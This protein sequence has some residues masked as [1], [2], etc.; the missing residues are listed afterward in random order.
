[1]K[2]KYLEATAKVLSKNKDGTYTVGFRCSDCEGGYITTSYT[3]ADKI[4][5][6][7]GDLV[8]VTISAITKD[9]IINIELSNGVTDASYMPD[10]IQQ[11]KDAG[12]YKEPEVTPKKDTGQ[13][14]ITEQLGEK[15]YKLQDTKTQKYFVGL[16]KEELDV[17][18]YADQSD[19]ERI[20]EEH[21]M[22]DYTLIHHWWDN[23]KF[24]HWDLFMSDGCTMTHMVLE[25]DPLKNFEIK[26]AQRQPYTDDFWLRGEKMESI[27]PGEPGNP[28]RDSECSIERIDKGKVAVY[29]SEQQA[30]ESYLLRLEFFGSALE[31]RWAFTSSV[32][33]VWHALKETTKL[34]EQFQTNIALSGDIAAWKETNDGLEVTGTALSFGTWNGLYWSP[35]VILNSPLDDFDNMIVDVE[36]DNDKIAGS[37]LEKKIDGPDVKEKFK[38]TDYEII[39]KIK[40]GTYT[41]LSIDARTFVDPIRRVV[42]GVKKYTR[43]TVCE[44]PACK[45]CYFGS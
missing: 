7:E 2:K 22:S 41:G 19:F 1:M 3:P 34:S 29:E 36:H 33:N 12:I 9:Q 20:A 42:A 24:E 30:D 39:E 25:G 26:A 11:A 10:L 28:S 44:N 4:E 13:Y 15:V 43:L 21:E 32:P 37:V 27:A 40:N 14:S 35:E 45:V 23:G 17:N 16:A 18:T 5:L 6:A 8:D 31:G 38:V